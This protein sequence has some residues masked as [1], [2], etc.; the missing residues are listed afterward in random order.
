M[1]N[2]GFR[3][4][5]IAFT[6]IFILTFKSCNDS[7]QGDNG[8]ITLSII[9]SIFGLII[10]LVGL[11]IGRQFKTSKEISE[12]EFLK[13]HKK[14]ILISTISLLGITFISNKLDIISNFNN[15]ISSSLQNNLENLNGKWEYSNKKQ[16]E[17]W[18]LEIS[19]D[20]ITK[21][22]NYVLN[23]Q[24][25]GWGVNKS[26]KMRTIDKGSFNLVEGFDRY[27]HKAYVGENPDTN[28]SIFLITEVDNKYAMD[29]M[30]RLRIIEEDMFGEKMNK[31][32][33]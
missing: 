13:R 3:G 21:S 33:N 29:W 5:I 1:K 8:Y 20:D 7:W 24:N 19:Y 12:I 18:F 32:S 14:I 31:T 10:G 9:S 11:V 15:S 25:E 2:Y 27:G 16:H 28:N 6:F 17:F 4:F 23:Q 26:S 22:G 30:L